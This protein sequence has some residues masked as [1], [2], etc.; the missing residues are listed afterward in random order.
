MNVEAEVQVAF[1]CADPQ[2]LAEFWAEAIPGY[3]FPPPPEGH[4][5][6]EG[7]AE[8]EGIPEAERNVMRV[9]ID[10]CGKRPALYFQRVPESK[11]AKNRLHLDVKISG[12][13][14]GEERGQRIEE[15]VVRLMKLGATVVERRSPPERWVVMADVEGNEFCVV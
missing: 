10:Q 12:G 4:L 7:W 11:S 15:E 8:G 3:A 1:D 6:W 13:L 9:L 14:S 2:R 5:S